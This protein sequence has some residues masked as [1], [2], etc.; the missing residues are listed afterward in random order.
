MTS[1][2]FYRFACFEP[3]KKHSATCNDNI[4]GQTRRISTYNEGNF[5]TLQKIHPTN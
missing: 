3:S 2:T 1:V 5:K 4:R